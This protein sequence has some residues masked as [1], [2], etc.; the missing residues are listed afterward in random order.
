[1]ADLSYEA[2]VARFRWEVPERFN[3]ATDI[4]ERHANDLT[5]V[6]LYWVSE[7]GE[8]RKIT[9]AELTRLSKRFAAVLQNIGVK[10]GDKVFLML[11]NVPEWW[12][13][14]LGC[15]RIGVILIPATTMLTSKDIM[16]R[17]TSSATPV[18]VTDAEGAAKVDDVRGEVPG[19]RQF[20]LVGGQKA[21]WKAFGQLMSR[22]GKIGHVE[23]TSSKDPMLI[24]FTSGTMGPPKM[25]LHTQA[26][27]GIGHRVT[28]KWLN[29]SSGDIHWTVTGTGWAKHAYGNLFGPWYSGATLFVFHCAGRFNAKRHLD[30]LQR[31]DITSFCAA[32]TAWR[33][34]VLEDLKSYRFPHLREVTSAG[35]PLNPEVIQKWKKITGLTIRDG[36]GQTECALVIAN[37]P[38]MDVKLGSMGK[39]SAGFDVAVIDEMGN[40]LGA[41]TEGDVAINI[42]PR[43]V[44]LFEG[45]YNNPEKTKGV[46]R[47]N[48][49]ITDDRAYID[50]DGYF[51][52]LGRADDVIKSSGYRIGPF[53]VESILLEHPAVAEAAAVASPD[54]LRGSIV[55]AFIVLKRGHIPSNELATQIMEF[56]KKMTAPYKHP[57]KIEF[58]DELPKTLTGKIRRNELRALEL[59]RFQAMK[60]GRQ[61]KA[62]A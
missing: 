8:E 22:A 47:G 4:F 52:F 6:A 14:A 1:V 27:Y 31:Y 51:W 53:E 61:D 34:I 42:K 35:E 23:K 59:E 58:V 55:K 13:I 3:W 18:V 40:R 37:F 26:S 12:E 32:P 20:I 28:A 11:S 15:I 7:S 45:Y 24:Y 48:W 39:P 16:Y 17:L 43:P 44:G 9:F 38:G 33:M 57:R 56:T 5:R 19:V 36:Y 25:V 54:E 2:W 10:K 30:I 50:N 60:T 62:A 21:G 49:Y 46:F 29:V 41:G